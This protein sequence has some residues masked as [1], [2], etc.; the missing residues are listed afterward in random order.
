MLTPTQI[1]QLRQERGWSQ[2]ALADKLGVNR[3]TVVRWE[4]GEVKAISALM[5]LLESTL[6]TECPDTDS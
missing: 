4:A 2:Q 3:T 1:R 5:G 6:E